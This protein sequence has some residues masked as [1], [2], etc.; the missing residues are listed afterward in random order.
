MHVWTTQT[1][2]A[3]KSKRFTEATK[4][5]DATKV[6]TPAEAMTTI[7]ETATAKFDE[8]VEVHVQ[9]GIDAR[10]GDQQVRATATLPHGTGKSV[11]VAVITSTHEKE[12]RDAGAEVVGG[13]ELIEKIKKGELIDEVD[14]IVATPEMM[15]KLAQVARILG[16]RGMMPNPKTETVTTNVAETVKS[17]KKGKI[18]F[19]NDKT[20]VI[21]QAIGKVSFDVDK[22]VEN[23]DAFIA[24]V[25]AARPAEYKGALIKSVKACSTMGPSVTIVKK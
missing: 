10:K 20:G 2:M 5:V 6:Y 13:E 19:R 12:A 1:H 7:K 14:V 25:E 3:K 22:L 11:R 21:H 15:P 4:K 23:Y 16:P 18:D 17:L 8:S 24:A 9:L